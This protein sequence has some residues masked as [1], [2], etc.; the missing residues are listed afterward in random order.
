MLSRVFS[1]I[2]I[3]NIILIFS[4]SVSTNHFVNLPSINIAFYIFFHITLIYILFFY[5][6]YSIFLLVFFY[7]ILMDI[8]LINLIGVHLFCFILLT[9]VFLISKKYLFLLSSFQITCAIFITLILT[10]YLEILVAYLLNDIYFNFKLI[11]KYLFLSI[12]IFIPSI[13]LLNKIDS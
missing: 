11:F 8:F 12:I 6:H 5:Y 9:I 13:F 2:I 10:L 3:F 7:G 4:F 1:P